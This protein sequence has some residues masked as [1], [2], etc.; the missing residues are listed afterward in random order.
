LKLIKR[1]AYGQAGVDFCGIASS[2]HL[3]GWQHSRRCGAAW[4]QG[5]PGGLGPKEEIGRGARPRER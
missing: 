3:P 1:Q 2:H 4:Q 5:H